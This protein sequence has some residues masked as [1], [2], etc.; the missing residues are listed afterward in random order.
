VHSPDPLALSCRGF[1]F[2]LSRGQAHSREAGTARMSL[3]AANLMC[4]TVRLST[5]C[6]VTVPRSLILAASAGDVVGE[7]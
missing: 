3:C 7:A 6:V 5:P 2:N 1:P 4:D